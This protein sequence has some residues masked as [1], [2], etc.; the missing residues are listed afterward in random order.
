M[1]EPW[2]LRPPE[3]PSDLA[4]D[5]FVAGEA[6]PE[7]RASVE[8]WQENDP[9]A[10]ALLA[11]RAAGLD[12][13]TQAR[14]AR[15]FQGALPV[16][17]V[18][19]MRTRA[20]RR[21]AIWSGVVVSFAAAAGLFIAVRSKSQGDGPDDPGASTET[22]RARGGATLHV[23][24]KR[25]EQLEETLSGDTFRT[26]D[27]LRFRVGGLNP[28]ES[29]LVAGVEDDGSLFAYSPPDGQSVH[30]RDALDA[31]GTFPGAAELDDSR[32]EEWAHLVH[33]PRAFTLGDL[34]T[35]DSG[36]RPM[37]QLHVPPGCGT[38]AFRLVKP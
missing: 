24:R 21:A 30:I 5:A 25:G 32:G 18:P 22:T 1:N 13:V 31:D 28:E 35:D 26:G 8:R 29:V 11:E 34:T 4:L 7:Q 9:G 15:R 19:P 33:C 14:M 37:G 10:A 38:T 20:P 12:T 6:T 16:A 27:R 2:N 36:D 3:M 17:S 23:F